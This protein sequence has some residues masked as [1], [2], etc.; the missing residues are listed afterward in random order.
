LK[1]V[2]QALRRLRRKVYRE[3]PVATW[4]RVAEIDH[5]ASYADLAA[6]FRDGDAGVLSGGCAI[7]LW[8]ACS[9][10][11]LRA[12]CYEFGFPESLT[13]MVTIVEVDGGLQVHDAFFNSSYP[14]GFYDLLNSL[15]AGIPVDP[16]PELRDRKTYIMDPAFEPETTVYWLEANAHRE[17]EP[18]DGLRRFEL[19]W[20]EETFAATLPTIEAAY[21]DLAARGYTRDLR[22]LMLHP[23]SVFDGVKYHRERA[24]MPLVGDLD[25]Q[26]PVATLRVATEQA[27]RELE[28]KRIQNSETKALVARLEAE[29]ARTSNQAARYENRLLQLR[30]ALEDAERAFAEEREA[31]CREKAE[32]DAELAQVRQA[33]E[34]SREETEHLLSRLAEGELHSDQLK[35][36]LVRVE[37]QATWSTNQVAIWVEKLAEH[38]KRTLGIPVSPAMDPSE[39]LDKVRKRLREI[40]RGLDRAEAESSQNNKA[41]TA[42]GY[43]SSIHRRVRRY[44]RVLSGV[45]YLLTPKY[46]A[47]SPRG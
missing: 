36:Q 9:D 1:D 29:L 15:R 42:A 26:S 10:R 35:G 46:R 40:E 3:T 17:L 45:G 28:S 41:A 24:T 2:S 16:E 30:V 18:I 34:A 25:L 14:V 33:L 32:L 44:C 4:S 8:R 37:E 5:Q 43:G 11:G 38:G 6:V 13:H 7:A 21:R 31:S 22:F 39:V 27:A 47:S 20:T 19:L 23:V 12:W